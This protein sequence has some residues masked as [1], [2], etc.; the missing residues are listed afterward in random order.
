MYERAIRLD[1][2]HSQANIEN[3]RFAQKSKAKRLSKAGIF[4]AYFILDNL[5]ST[6]A[7]NSIALKTET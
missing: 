5:D 3:K 2:C 1:Q 7:R 4:S 6:L